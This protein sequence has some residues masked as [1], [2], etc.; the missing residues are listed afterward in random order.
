MPL[1]KISNSKA[2]TWRRCPKK[3]K[4]KYV[5]GLRPKKRERPL[6][7]GTWMHKLVETHY[8]GGNWKKVHKDYVKRY[9]GLFLE[10]REELGDLPNDCE[11]LMK[12]Y[13]RNYEKED[14]FWFPI[15]Q[16]LNEYVTLPSGLKL[17][18]VVDLVVEDHMGI[19]IVDHKFRGR[20]SDRS[21]SMAL[22]PQLTLYFWAMEQLGY[23]P[24]AGAIYNEVRTKAPAIPAKLKS[25]RLSQRANI[26]TDIWTYARAVKRNGEDLADYA[27]ILRIIASRQR[28]RFFRRTHLPKDAP[29]VQTMMRELMQTANEIN[30]AERRRAY[31]RTYDGTATGCKRCDYNSICI[32]QLHGGDIKS[33]IQSDYIKKTGDAKEEDDLRERRAA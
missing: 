5:M 22:D 1:E 26:D 6:E 25:G 11:R 20:F 13:L 28:E 16:E 8:G 4:Y 9:N 14:R 17:N 2:N 18:V 19:W 27:K 31:P 10:I 3:Y 24:L 12:S 23:S 15:D 7:M 21:S 33:I 32:S 29:V 30:A